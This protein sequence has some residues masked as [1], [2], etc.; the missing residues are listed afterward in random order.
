MKGFGTGMNEVSSPLGQR[1][2]ELTLDAEQLLPLAEEG[3]ESRSRY[4]SADPYVVALFV[5]PG[6]VHY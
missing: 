1:V 2:A 6:R 4:G 3:V 5:D